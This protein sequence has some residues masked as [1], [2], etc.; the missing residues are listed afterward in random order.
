[1]TFLLFQTPLTFRRAFA[2]GGGVFE[3]RKLSQPQNLA[4]I[5][6]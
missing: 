4:S 3:A 6:A 2:R 5:L 1:M